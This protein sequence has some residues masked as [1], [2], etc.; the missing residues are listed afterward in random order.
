MHDWFIKIAGRGEEARQS[1]VIENGKWVGS[2]TIALVR[3]G[4]GM[5]QAYNPPWARMSGPSFPENLS[6]RKKA[7]TVRQMIGQLPTNVSYFLTMANESDFRLFV[8]EGFEPVL[9]EN[10]TIPPDRLPALHDSLSKMTKRHIRQAQRDLFV[11]T[12]TPETFI[13]TYAAH[14]RARRR[15]A[16]APIE[17]ALDILREGIRRDQARIFTANRRDTG[18]IDAAIACLWDDKSY[19]YWMTTRRPPSADESKPHQGAVKLLLQSAIQ[20]AAT[21]GLTFDFD[22]VGVDSPSG[23]GRSKLYEGM[24]AQ[25][26]VRYWVRRETRLERILHRFRAPVKL[27]IRNTF[28]CFMRLKLNA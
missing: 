28:G 22:G 12:T 21:R 15:K 27:A 2:L 25:R 26:S 8:S 18:E 4:L 9:E 23:C 11:S 16:Y 20:D 17:I 5:K 3:N 13:E 1:V 10:F 7:E 6:E 24:G 19:Y 14:L